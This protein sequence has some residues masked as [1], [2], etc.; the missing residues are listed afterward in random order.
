[1]AEST[2]DREIREIRA[3]LHDISELH[4]KSVIEREKWAAERESERKKDDKKFKRWMAQF[5]DYTE[6]ESK[7]L[8]DEFYDALCK[9]KQIDGADLQEIHVRL[10]AMRASQNI[11]EYDLVA[12]NGDVV[13]VGEIKHNLTAQKVEK[14]ANGQLQRFAKHFPAM[15]GER[16]V[17]GM[18]GGKI[19]E[20]KVITAAQKLGL[21]VLRLNNNRKLSVTTPG[22]E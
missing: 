4:Q 7:S 9:A 11:G 8:E 18:V 16:R 21:Y 12:V 15:T 5:G 2:H 19:I 20:E 14:F 1:M 6:T 13:F 22:R 3:I 10:H 17:L